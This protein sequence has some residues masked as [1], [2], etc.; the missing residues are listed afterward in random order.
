[1]WSRRKKEKKM[2][3][4]EESDTSH[5]DKGTSRGSEEA[6]KKITRTNTTQ[7]DYNNHDQKHIIILGSGFAGIE[8][9]KRL[10]KKF[11]NN[12]HVAITLVSSDNFVLFTPMLPEVAS[13]M[14]L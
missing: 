4:T 14:T 1:M 8:V 2:K 11:K 10:Q 9:V 5:D 3:D 12:E 7:P 13:G 6:T